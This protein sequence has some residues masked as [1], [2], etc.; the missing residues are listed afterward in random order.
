MIE[1]IN[2][3]ASCSIELKSDM[4]VDSISDKIIF[5]ILIHELSASTMQCLKI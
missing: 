5:L 4:I 3:A 1:R 2:D